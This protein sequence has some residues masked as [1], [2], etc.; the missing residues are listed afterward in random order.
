MFM[1]QD[2]IKRKNQF[3]KKKPSVSPER[4]QH[5]RFFLEYFLCLRQLIAEYEKK[6]SLSALGSIEQLRDDLIDD[7]EFS[8]YSFDQDM[9]ES[10]M[11][12]AQLMMNYIHNQ[13]NKLQN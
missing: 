13:R 4:S 7:I 10:Y 3:S 12:L 9:Y 5:F 6:P 8:L 2:Y 1:N 11:G